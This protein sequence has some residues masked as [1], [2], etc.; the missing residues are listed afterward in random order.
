MKSELDIIYLAFSDYIRGQDFFDILHSEK[1]GYLKI[2]TGALE[3]IASAVLDTP[4]KMLSTLFYNIIGDVVCSS[5]DPG[6]GCNDLSV[7]YVKTESCRR[8]MAILKTME[9]ESRARCLD[10]MD[11]YFEKYQERCAARGL[12]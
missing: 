12:E 2:P 11:A 6:S 7:S 8:I 3:S 4:E 1:P 9:E 5:Y 10:F